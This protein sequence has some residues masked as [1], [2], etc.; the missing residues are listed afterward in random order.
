MTERDAD[1]AGILLALGAS[2]FLILFSIA[3]ALVT[4]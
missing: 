2:V 4:M 1:L 3:V